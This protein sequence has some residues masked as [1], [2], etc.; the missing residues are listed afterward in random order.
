MAE[1]Y[2]T[3]DEQIEALKKWWRE[4]GRSTVIGIALAL[5]A[6]FGWQMW[7]RNQAERTEQAS[8]LYQD[9]L[10]ADRAAD[11]DPDKL[12]T[13]RHLAEQL[14][15]DYGNLS[16]GVFGAMFKAK[17]AVQAGEPEAAEQE[18]RWVLQQSPDEQ[19]SEQARIR[20]AH[21]LLSQ[22]KY[23]EAQKVL[24]GTGMGSYAAMIAELRGD[25]H[26]AKGENA[27]ALAA[28]EEAKAELAQSPDGGRNTLLDMKIR[29]LQSAEP[30][31]TAGVEQE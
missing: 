17:Y 8:M 6:V 29:N 30:A 28:Y 20:L 25:I 26:L 18:L 10:A 15:Q 1:S 24:E 21:V 5:G 9:L 7:E 11:S 3:E 23:E 27:Q 2:R 12:T 16:Y 19:L 4:N 13:A 14:K 31:A 22:K